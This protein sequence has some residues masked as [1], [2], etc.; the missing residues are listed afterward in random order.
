MGL[1]AGSGL[2][3]RS[4]A[5][6]PPPPAAELMAVQPQFAQP[7]VA[8][9]PPPA[10][11]Q[12]PTAVPVQVQPVP[13]VYG[14]MTVVQKP[15]SYTNQWSSSLCNC[16]NLGC[17]FCLL[18]SCCPCIVFGQEA[19]LLVNE[20]IPFLSDLRPYGCWLYCA[21]DHLAQCIGSPIPL[22]WVFGMQ[23]RSAVRDR[24]GIKEEPCCDCC[25]ACCCAPCALV[26]EMSELRKHNAGP[27]GI[28][29]PNIFVNGQNLVSA[30]GAVNH[31]R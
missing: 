23:A 15:M 28:N 25:V 31:M 20:E 14:N 13:M 3:P 8:G 17:G 26:Q 12:T 27:N 9:A 10:Y 19:D 5:S 7:A 4:G 2:D 16:C 18:A 30:P 1:A 6:A 24:Y 21:A 29:A 22:G 11:N